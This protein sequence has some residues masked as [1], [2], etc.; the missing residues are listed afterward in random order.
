MRAV[1]RPIGRFGLPLPRFKGKLRSMAEPV[2]RRPLRCVQCGYDLEG[3]SARGACPEC[4]REIVASL[5][6]GL[7]LA[8]TDAPSLPDARRL[9]WAL[10]LA[11]VGCLAASARLPELGLRAAAA[12]LDARHAQGATEALAAIASA[13]HVVA[14]AGAMLG[15]V[16]LA[17]VLPRR[18]ER[19]VLRIRVLGCVGFALWTAISLVPPNAASLTATALP[20]AMSLLAL[21]PILREL[22][23]RSRVYR[24]RESA[25]QRIDELLL[26]LGVAGVA[27]GCAE[28]GTLDSSNGTLVTLLRLVAVASGGLVLVGLCYL[29]MNS[30]WILRAILR[31]DPT[32]SEVL[33]EV[34]PDARKPS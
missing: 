2:I 6:S 11:T 27:A 10:M 21:S 17:V 19:R 5:A 13:L 30:Y 1:H 32:L 26:A 22:G 15:L 34:G 33:G 28:F 12:E 4:G 25:K 14:I 8:A 9:A 16:A 31:P 18:D 23:P 29:A 24:D 3:L 20:A 7:D